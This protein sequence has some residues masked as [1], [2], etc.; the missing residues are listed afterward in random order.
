MHNRFN[1][2]EEEKK[3][4]RTL[5]GMQVINE[6]DGPT[7]EKVEELKTLLH[8][9]IDW[10]REDEQLTVEAEGVCTAGLKNLNQFTTKFTRWGELVDLATEIRNSIKWDISPIEVAALGD[11]LCT[12]FA[13]KYNG[14]WNII[15][16]KFPEFGFDK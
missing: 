2:N 8:E 15:D 3:H 5:H 13:Q 14:D 7:P 4:I 11:Y 10:I 12:A 6:L 16:P 9:W 1:L